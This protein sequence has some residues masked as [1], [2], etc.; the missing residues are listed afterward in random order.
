V[1]E[2]S[3]ELLFDEFALQYLRGERPRVQEYLER[4]G[5]KREE[6]AS[7]LDRFLQ[8]APAREPAEE[9]VVLMQARLEQEPP[10]LVLRVRRKLSRAA[11]VDALVRTLGLDPGTRD[12]VARYYHELETG[13][14]DPEPVDRR[15]WEGLSGFLRA[16]VRALAGLR[17]PPP[18]AAPAFRAADE[19][20]RLERLAAPRPR[21][22]EGPD[23]VDRLFTG[24]T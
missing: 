20:F 3:V 18:A 17:P 15:V 21:P 2:V 7:L 9:E 19:S 6:L 24:G 10:L 22:E 13:L 11:V 4:A 8:A 5:A 23:E 1:N 16:N 12:K 14:L